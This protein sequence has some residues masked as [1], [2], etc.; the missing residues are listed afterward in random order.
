MEFVKI[1]QDVCEIMY[2]SIPIM[3]RALGNICPEFNL[4]ANPFVMFVQGEL[5][6]DGENCC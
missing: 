1:C 6:F 3:K 2:S 5:N 4:S